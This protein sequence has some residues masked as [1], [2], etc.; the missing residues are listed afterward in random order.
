MST[1]ILNWLNQYPIAWVPAV[2]ILC[3]LIQ[4]RMRASWHGQGCLDALCKATFPWFV[5]WGIGIYYILGTL[6][7][8]TGM[9][10][11]AAS[12]MFRFAAITSIF[13][14]PY[15]A[16]A[17]TALIACYKRQ[18]HFY[19]AV[20]TLYIVNNLGIALSLLGSIVYSMSLAQKNSAN[21]RLQLLSLA[22]TLI[23]TIIAYTL[24]RKAK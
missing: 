17:I 4:L 10:T 16:L 13:A 3:A 21:I 24:Y 18:M 6:T 1:P 15:L 23:L 14:A 7:S 12:N 2:S 5:A 20:I 22:S 9:H 11:V 19:A 8:I